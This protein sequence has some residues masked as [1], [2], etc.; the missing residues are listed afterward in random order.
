MQSNITS[1]P[2]L[3]V[4]SSGGLAIFPGGLSVNKVRTKIGNTPLRYILIPSIQGLLTHFPEVTTKIEVL[5]YYIPLANRK[6]IAR[7]SHVRTERV[8]LR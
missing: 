4:G 5:P 3:A 7:K 1:A 8:E 6:Q 2:N